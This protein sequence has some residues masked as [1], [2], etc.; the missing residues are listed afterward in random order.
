M[1][2]SS[3]GTATATRMGRGG[4]EGRDWKTPALPAARAIRNQ[5]AKA[6]LRMEDMAD[7]LAAALAT[8][9]RGMWIPGSDREEPRAQRR[10]HRLGATAGAELREDGG[11]VE[12][13]RVA[14]DGE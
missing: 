14:R 8:R 11:D 3:G 2:K 6:M 1:P 10:G 9:R 7:L 13:H 5:S 4:A 12:L